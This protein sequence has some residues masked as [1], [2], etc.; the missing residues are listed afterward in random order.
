MRR[1]TFLDGLRGLAALQVVLGHYTSAFLPT[2][3]PRLGVLADGQCAV[4]LFFLMS[5]FVLTPSFIHAK[6]GPGTIILRRLVRLGLPALVACLFAAGIL[7]WSPNLGRSAALAVHSDW[8]VS[9][10]GG[11]PIQ[12]FLSDLTGWSLVAGFSETSL[13]LK[14]IVSSQLGSTNPPTWTLHIELWGSLWVLILCTAW[15]HSRRIYQCLLLLSLPMLGAN[16]ISLFTVGHLWSASSS[17]LSSQRWL[18]PRQKLCVGLTSCAVGAVLCSFFSEPGYAPAWVT[19]LPY[20]FNWFDWH[21]ELGALAIFLGVMSVP[22]LQHVLEGKLPRFF[23]SL[24]FPIYLTHWPIMIVIGSFTF[25]Q[26]K[27]SGTPSA[28]MLALAVGLLVTIPVALAFERT[29]DLPAIRLSKRL[30][31]RAS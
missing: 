22:G 7:F 13:F 28:A 14:P 25:E 3:N 30:V 2:I 4:F 27:S 10:T 12:T 31:F 26:A 5:G 9:V 29:C 21:K 15:R 8:L 20:R 6:Q 24:S 16:P 23:G 17:A 11:Y 1:V 19:G 18:S